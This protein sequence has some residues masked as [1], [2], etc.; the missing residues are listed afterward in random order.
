MIPSL[1]FIFFALANLTV[2]QTTI[3]RDGGTINLTHVAL[4]N[5]ATDSSTLEVRL[6]QADLLSANGKRI[7]GAI[8]HG[9][10]VTIFEPK[11]GLFW[12][13][14]Q[15]TAPND[16]LTQVAARF[17]NSHGFAITDREIISFSAVGRTLFTRTSTLKFRNHQNGI[18]AIELTLEQ[19]LPKMVLGARGSK[20]TPLPFSSSFFAY[21]STRISPSG[22]LMTLRIRGVS[23]VPAGWKVDIAN[24]RD[25][26]ATVVL[27]P[28]LTLVK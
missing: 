27:T 3:R 2:A 13:F 15:G 12:W 19:E 16:D 25:E 20:Q 7:S 1:I 6:S 28:L 17:A 9:V 18:D 10:I 5:T 8:S 11:T 4:F 24:E 26:V 22:T 14:H 23:Q 21:G